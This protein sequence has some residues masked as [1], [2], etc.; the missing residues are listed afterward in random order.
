VTRAGVRP[1]QEPATEPRS[2]FGGG[3]PRY[4]RSWRGKKTPTGGP[5][6][7]RGDSGFNRENLKARPGQPAACGGV[8]VTV[9]RVV[10]SRRD[11]CGTVTYT[12]LNFP[13]RSRST[14]RRPC[15][16]LEGWS[17]LVS[18]RAIIM[19]SMIMMISDS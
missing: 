17:L 16:Q 3:R 5:A 18:R 6:A 1:G 11:H 9:T 10:T 19:D 15:R 4:G 8:T 12:Q 7:A 2:E 14:V 13:D